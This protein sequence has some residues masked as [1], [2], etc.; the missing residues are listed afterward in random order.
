L[1]LGPEV[2]ISPIYIPESLEG[3]GGQEREG[4]NLR[5]WQHPEQGATQPVG[6]VLQC[7]DEVLLSSVRACLLVA[8]GGLDLFS[9]NLWEALY[10]YCSSYCIGW[11]PILILLG[12]SSRSADL[13]Y[14]GSP[15]YLNKG[16]I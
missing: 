11:Q 14:T 10:L 1:R 2:S 16:Q 5:V 15:Y 8:F 7:I 12:L 13:L 4:R 3:F 9:Y 6:E